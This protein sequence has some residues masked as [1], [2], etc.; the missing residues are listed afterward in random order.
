MPRKENSEQ[1]KK[2][3][4][5]KTKPKQTNKQKP[6]VELKR[7]ALWETAATLSHTPVC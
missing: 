5:P 4:K 6:A 1:K 7:N 3:K 2:P